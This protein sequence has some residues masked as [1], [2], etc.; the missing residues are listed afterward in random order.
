MKLIQKVMS[1]C[2]VKATNNATNLQVTTLMLAWKGLEVSEYF[3]GNLVYSC[4]SR[5]N[6]KKNTMLYWAQA[7]IK[8]QLTVMGTT[9]GG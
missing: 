6:I 4:I 3:Q 1:S 7:M 9:R 8:N 2:H 5:S